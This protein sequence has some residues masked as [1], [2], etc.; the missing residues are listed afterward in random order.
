MAAVQYYGGNC[1]SYVPSGTQGGC[2]LIQEWYSYNQAGAR[3]SKT[4]SVTRGSANRSL[5]A[6]WTYDTEGRVVSA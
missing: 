5:T 3:L 1:S 4:L 6:N 2:D